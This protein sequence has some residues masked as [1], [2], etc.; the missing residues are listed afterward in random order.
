MANPIDPDPRATLRGGLPD[1]YL[2]PDDIAE[3]FEVPKETVYQW[4]K[5]RIGPPGFRI[6]KYVRYDPADVRAYV[7]QRKHAETAAA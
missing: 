7:D 2:T 4:R 6:G 5:K 3:I 1:R